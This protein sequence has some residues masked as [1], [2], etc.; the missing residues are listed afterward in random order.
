M[1]Q[2]LPGMLAT[3]KQH[4]VFFFLYFIFLLITLFLQMNYS[5]QEL[6]LWVNGHHTP[7]SDCFFYYYTDFGDGITFLVIAAICLFIRYK[8]SVYALL[9][10]LTTSQ[11]TQFFKRV[12]FSDEPRPKK[13]FEATGEQLHM[14]DGIQVHSMMSFPSGHS[15]TAFAIAL[16]LTLTVKNK[17][18][19]PVF[20]L[21]A[22]MAGYSRLYVAQHF[23]ADVVMGSVIGVFVGLITYVLL[24]RS[25]LANKP[26]M[27]KK[28][29][30]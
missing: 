25:A 6:F 3:I 28:L 30:A 8:Y 10:Y 7:L 20:L 22:I 14:L 4:K 29:F 24:E 16:F 26:W 19:S 21:L 2:T 27:N 12:V 9:I 11:V 17:Y 13:F 23:F 18:W 1:L 15:T 5:K